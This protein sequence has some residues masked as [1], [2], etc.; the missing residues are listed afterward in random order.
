MDDDAKLKAL[1]AEIDDLFAN[2]SERRLAFGVKLLELNLLLAEPGRGTFTETL[3]QRKIPLST[4]YRA[5]NYARAEL[6]K[7]RLCRYG[8]DD[9]GITFTWEELEE[10]MAAASPEEWKDR[11]PRPRSKSYIV[12]TSIG[13]LVYEEERRQLAAAWKI[14]K[15][16]ESLHKKLST[17]FIREIC[18]AAD[19][20]EKRVKRKGRLRPARASRAARVAG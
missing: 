13:L 19:K 4:A 15:S 6:E 7:K 16:E 11:P 10:I 18:H 5:M 9:D 2:Y 20:F 8:K 17:R 1:L 14:I 3:Q 12:Q